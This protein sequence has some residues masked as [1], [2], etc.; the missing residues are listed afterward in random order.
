MTVIGASLITYH[1]AAGMQHVTQ[2][3]LTCICSCVITAQAFKDQ[4][5]KAGDIDNQ[6]GYFRAFNTGPSGPLGNDKK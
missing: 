2:L 5:D 3:S 6:S 4:G 1:Q